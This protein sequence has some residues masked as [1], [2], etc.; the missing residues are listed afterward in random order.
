MKITL[1]NKV[2][3][4]AAAKAE[5]F[6]HSHRVLDNITQYSTHIHAHAFQELPEKTQFKLF[7]FEMEYLCV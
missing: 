3:Y 5:L 7:N 1:T 2:D 4:R 6:I